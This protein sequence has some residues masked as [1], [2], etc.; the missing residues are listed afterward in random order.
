MIWPSID[1]LWAKVAYADYFE[2]REENIKYLKQLQQ[3]DDQNPNV[4]YMFGIN[5]NRIGQYDKGILEFEMCLEISRKWGKEFLKENYVYPAL[6]EMYHITG[7]YKKEKKIYREAERVNTDH[8]SIYFSWIIRDQ[9]TLSLTEG[10][11]VAANSYIEKFISVLKENS[12]S[13]ADIAAG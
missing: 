6:G 10:D 9:A 11:T 13:D 12:S 8:K 1:Q 3:I 4:Y 5:Y 2:T 7:Q